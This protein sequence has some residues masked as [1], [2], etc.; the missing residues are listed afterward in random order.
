MGGS[1]HSNVS[2]LEAIRLI[3][4]LGGGR[5]NYELSDQARIGDHIWYIS[6]VRRFQGD[7]PA[8]RVLAATIEDILAEMIDVVRTEQRASASLPAVPRV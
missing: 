4:E 2:M 7:Y 8:W 1:R 3:E 5:L 6:D